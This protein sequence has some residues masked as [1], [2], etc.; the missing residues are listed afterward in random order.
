MSISTAS[1]CHQGAF[2]KDAVEDAARQLRDSLGGPADLA[3]AFITPDFLPHLAEFSDIIRV[4][5]HISELVGS[6]GT[7]TIFNEFEN[8][9][10]PGFS[11][12][13]VR[14]PESK[15]TVI[16]QS[17]DD[18]RC[19]GDAAW[20]T[21]HLPVT[22]GIVLMANPF[23]FPAEDWLEAFNQAFPGTPVVG[24]LASGGSDEASMAVFHNHRIVEGAVLLGFHGDLHLLPVVSQGCRPIGEPLPVTKVEHNVVYSLGA[25]PAYQALEAAFESLTD[26]EKSGAQGNLF[27]GLANNEYVD[28]FKSGDFL[29]RNI[30]G[31]DPGSGAVVIAGIPRLG[32]TLQY[33]IRDRAAAD[34]DLKRA[35]DRSWS[36]GVHEVLGSLIFSCTGRGTGMFEIPNHDAATVQR[37]AGV[38]PSAGFFCN[39][40]VGPVSKKNCPHS[41]TASIALLCVK[42]GQPR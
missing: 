21:R 14:S 25:R 23:H 15:P 19:G 2:S 3:I 34:S 30:I 31:A 41:Y 16:T 29:I 27:V 36:R 22:K 20:M 17:A 42:R 38:H 7:G 35:L 10:G 24:G 4:D 26:E 32:Q 39:G 9:G 6:T 5:G 12:L 13:A 28:E 33:Q 8:E 37:A 18:L 40:E 11:I 1:V